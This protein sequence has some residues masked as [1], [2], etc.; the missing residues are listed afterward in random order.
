MKVIYSFD[1]KHQLNFA[2]SKMGLRTKTTGKKKP[3]W[4][5]KASL[6]S[7]CRK[8]KFESSLADFLFIKLSK[9]EIN[10][11]NSWTLSN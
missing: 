4:Q 9:K 6:P 1:C 5:V 11:V 10:S 8:G 7:Y 3:W 2:D